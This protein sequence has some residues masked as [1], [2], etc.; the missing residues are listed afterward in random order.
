LRAAAPRKPL[1]LDQDNGATSHTEEESW[2]ID[3]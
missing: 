3:R 1:V 2:T